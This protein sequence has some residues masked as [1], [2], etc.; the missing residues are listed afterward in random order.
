M[1]SFFCSGGPW[2]CNRFRTVSSILRNKK[3]QK[4]FKGFLLA[5]V[6]SLLVEISLQCIF[7]KLKPEKSPFSSLAFIYSIKNLPWSPSKS[8]FRRSPGSFSSSFRAL[9]LASWVCTQANIPQYPFTFNHPL[10]TWHNVT[11]FIFLKYHFDFLK[12][13]FKV[14]KYYINAFSPLIYYYVFPWWSFCVSTQRP[15]IFFSCTS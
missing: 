4:F 12:S 7:P 5:R 9:S 2:L 1:S 13:I 15:T 6:Y 11:T 10:L 3:I 14:D 8:L